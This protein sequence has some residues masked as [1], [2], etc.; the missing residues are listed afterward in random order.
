M[1]RGRSTAI[2]C[3]A[4]GLAIFSFIWPTRMREKIFT[5]VLSISNDCTFFAVGGGGAA[6]HIIFDVWL[7]LK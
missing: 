1:P 3:L 5:D 6:V 2:I 4:V 7:I